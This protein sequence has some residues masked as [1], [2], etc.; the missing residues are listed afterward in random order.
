[1]ARYSHNTG[2][3]W[4]QLEGWSDISGMEFNS[5]ICKVMHLG[6]HKKI[7]TCLEEIVG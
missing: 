5:E 2:G 6:P 7:W 1:M 4:D 3:K